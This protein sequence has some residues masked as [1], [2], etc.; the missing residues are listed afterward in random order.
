M[1]LLVD[2]HIF[3]WWQ[4]RSPDLPEVA[5]AALVNREN[6]AIVSA[7]T[8]WEISIKRTTGRLDFEGDAIAACTASGFELLSMTAQHA[9]RAG[10]LPFHH[11]DPF[12]RM[13]VAQAEIEGLVLVTQD[14]KL[15]P[16][17]VAVLG[18]T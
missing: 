6:R 13:L 18:V 17:G 7:A 11:A 4:W 3:L 12:D 5:R 10:S 15:L 16:Y 14:R 8:I 1:N 9:E 2:T